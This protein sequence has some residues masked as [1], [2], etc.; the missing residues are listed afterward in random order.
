MAAEIPYTTC[1][2]GAT[3]IVLAHTR[4]GTPILLDPLPTADG[5]V[6]VDFEN[7]QCQM[8]PASLVK[9]HAVL[10]RPHVVSCLA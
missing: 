2:C 5:Y 4:T 10:W 3:V 8:V 7:G 9:N 1:R 6:R